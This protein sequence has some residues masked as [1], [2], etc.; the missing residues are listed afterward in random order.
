[1]DHSVVLGNVRND[2]VSI[3]PSAEDCYFYFYSSCGKVRSVLVTRVVSLVF[4]CGIGRQVSIS[5]L[6]GGYRLG[7]NVFAVVERFLQQRCV[8]F[9]TQHN[10]GWCAYNR[11]VV[12]LLFRRAF[13]LVFHSLLVNLRLGHW[14]LYSVQRQRSSIPCYWENQPSGCLKMHCP[15]RHLKPHPSVPPPLER[16]DQFKQSCE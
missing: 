13:F 2:A 15:F 5:S 14:S 1:M 8:R 7:R 16:V 12:Y 10:Q 4:V 3:N 6:F 11:T 9:Q